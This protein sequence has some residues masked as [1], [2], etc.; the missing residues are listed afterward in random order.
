MTSSALLQ[1]PDLIPARMLNEYAYCPRLSYLEWVQGEFAHS[2]DTLDGVLQHRRVDKPG[3]DLPSADPDAVDD[4]AP[5]PDVIHA[6][7]VQLSSERLGLTA[8]L[9]LIEGTSPIDG[10][11]PL[12]SPV[13]YKR[14]HVPDN[15]ER[16]WEPERV[17][18][19]AQALILRD[20]GYRCDDGVIYYVA[21]R[22][23]VTVVFDDALASRTLDLLQQMRRMPTEGQMPPP[24][25]N[26]PKC[27]GCSLAGICLPD[28]TRLLADGASVSTTKPEDEPRLRQLIPSRDDGRPLY[29]QEQRAYI[30]K[31]GDV[32]QVRS[33][34]KEA[35]KTLAEIR[36]SELLHVCLFGNV[37]ISTQLV[38]ELCDRQIPIAYFSY[39]GFF[40]GFTTGLPGKNIDL[41]INQYRQASDIPF[42]LAIARAITAGKIENQRT[43]LRRNHADVPQRALDDLRCTMDEAAAAEVLPC[44]LGTEGNAAR[45][46]FGQ[47]PGMLR[48]RDGQATLDFGFETRNRRPPTDPINAML[49]LG[50][51]MLAKDLT[52]ACWVVGLDPFLGFYHQPRYG[53]PALALDLMEEFRALIVDSTVL[54]AVNTGLVSPGDFL[55]R[56][57]AV[58]MK[59]EGRRRFIQAYERRLDSLVTHPLFGYRVSY[60]RVLEI[61]ARILARVLLGEIP[62]YVAFTTR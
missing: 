18:L 30:G 51:A 20:N 36:M 32:V 60:R 21:S 29:V 13:D 22:T 52:I 46:Y 15:P 16:S 43:M 57:P 14:G 58:A 3:G 2:A 23:R 61:Q 54:T 6:R 50:Y 4:D 42:C 1:P 62:R 44:L 47:F 41:R 24:L 53:R 5:A 38:Q 31:K 12:V 8:V 17:Q 11:P 49:S 7:S 48:P 10:G 55:R 35:P 19:C 39:G 28:E 56:G 40:H 45:T 26:S 37:Q 33:A 25:D 27:N 9:D 59:A 34:D